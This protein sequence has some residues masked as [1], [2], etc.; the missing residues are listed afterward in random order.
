MAL[1]RRI[2]DT[3]IF[4][5]AI[6]LFLLPLPMGNNRIY[7]AH[8]IEGFEQVLIR[9]NQFAA[10]A[11][12]Q[13]VLAGKHDYRGIFEMLV[14]FEQRASLVAIQARH[15][16]INKYDIGLVLHHFSQSIQAVFGQHH[17]ASR[18]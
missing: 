15:H 16:H 3:N 14:V 1:G 12:K 2:I 13:R 9:A 7:Q 18:L 11:I 6:E 4:L 8:Y 10:R 5:I 17:L